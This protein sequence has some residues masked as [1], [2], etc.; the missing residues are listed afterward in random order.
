MLF[1]NAWRLALLFLVS[2]FATR[3]MFGSGDRRLGSLLGERS[4]RLLIPTLFAVVV[5]IPVQPWIELVTQHGYRSGFGHFLERDYFRFGKLDGIVLPTWQH[6]WF[7]VYLWVYTIVLGGLLSWRWP[8][9]M[10]QRFDR[11]FGGWRA[12]ALPLAWL[13]LFQ[14]LLVKRGVETHALFDDGPAHL[15]YLPV[16]LFGFGLSGS[17]SV[18]TYF[19]RRWRGAIAAA[20]IA[21][22]IVAAIEWIWPGAAVPPK[23]IKP[24]AIKA[25]RVSTPVLPCGSPNHPIAARLAPPPCPPPC[26]GSG[27]PR[28][29]FAARGRRFRSFGYRLR[30][31][32]LAVV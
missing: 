21:Y 6:L 1:P 30:E 7:V 20:L 2:G 8:A 4:R 17:P 13:M 29:R 10:Q 26:P 9:D 22:V 32:A 27:L 11:W 3:R 16:F 14:V 12:F 24:P 31:A 28:T 23:P 18:L 5:I 25:N 15:A 19:A